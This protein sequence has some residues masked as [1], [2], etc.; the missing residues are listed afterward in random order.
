S[1]NASTNARAR[2]QVDGMFGSINTHRVPCSML[3]ATN[4]AKR[5]ADKYFQSEAPT[6]PAA[7]VRGL[8]PCRTFEREET[9]VFTPALD[10]RT[11][12]RSETTAAGRNPGRKKDSSLSVAAH[13]GEV[14]SERAIIPAAAPQDAKVS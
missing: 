13:N 3:D 6:P 10:S 8:K 5:R 11:R 2:S 9:R 1:R 12:S 14:S 7:S 4:S